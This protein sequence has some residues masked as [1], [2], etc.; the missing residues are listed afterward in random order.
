MCLRFTLLALLAHAAV[1]DAKRRIQL[2]RAMSGTVARVY[3][4][5]VIT[6]KRAHFARAL[7][8]GGPV[9]LRSGWIVLRES[10]ADLVPEYGKRNK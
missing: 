9:G 1:A 10:R 4:G 5:L 3:L 2:E 6:T 8:L 7:H